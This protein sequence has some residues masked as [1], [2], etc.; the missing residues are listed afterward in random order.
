MR[1]KRSAAT[2]AGNGAVMGMY[3]SVASQHSR[4]AKRFSTQTQFECLRGMALIVLM[5]KQP[6]YK[7]SNYLPRHLMNSDAMSSRPPHTHEM[8]PLQIIA[9]QFLASSIWQSEM[10]VESGCFACTVHETFRDYL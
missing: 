1:Q 2:A 3:L 10:A 4:M 7:N 5:G 9:E 8:P 6:P